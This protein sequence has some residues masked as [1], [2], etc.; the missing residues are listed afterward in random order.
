MYVAND[1]VIYVPPYKE[2]AILLVALLI[3]GV[4]QTIMCY[5]ERDI[6]KFVSLLPLG[7]FGLMYWSESVPS[8]T[9]ETLKVLDQCSILLAVAIHMLYFKYNFQYFFVLLAICFFILEN[10]YEHIWLSYHICIYLCLLIS[11]L[12]TY[13]EIVIISV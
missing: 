10:I 2:R 6:Y 4:I 3:N 12:S 1:W 8:N 11:F 13:Y 5:I 9:R 7:L